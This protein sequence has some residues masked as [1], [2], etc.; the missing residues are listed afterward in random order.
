MSENYEPVWLPVCDSIRHVFSAR[1]T[2]QVA[3]RVFRLMTFDATERF[4]SRSYIGP[5]ANDG[6]GRCDAAAKPSD[7]DRRTQ[8]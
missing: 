3:K 7:F 1:V 5:D 8:R 6:H 2:G 4:L